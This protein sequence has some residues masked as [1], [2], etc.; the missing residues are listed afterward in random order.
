MS[1]I[2]QA[3]VVE[4]HL[5]VFP[6]LR[7]VSLATSTDETRAV[8]MAI[9]VEQE[10]EAHDVHYIATNGRFL[11]KSKL[12]PGFDNLEP[13]RYLVLASNRSRMILERDENP[14]RFPNWRHAFPDKLEKVEECDVYERAS[15]K[16]CLITGQLF[17]TDYLLMA[18]GLTIPGSPDTRSVKIKYDD[19][20]KTSPILIE[21]ELGEAL[22]MPMRH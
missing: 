20:A 4:K 16:I 13:G 21:H 9:S 1:D 15:A 22:V 14:D 5:E 7:W 2:K 8:L 17:Q 12:A 3:I 6:L 11:F 19:A 10:S 18:C